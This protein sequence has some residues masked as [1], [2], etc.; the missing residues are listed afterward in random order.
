MAPRRSQRKALLCQAQV[1]LFFS[2]STGHTEDVAG[3][4]KEVASL[5]PQRLTVE[6][7]RGREGYP[8]VALSNSCLSPPPPGVPIPVA[9]SLAVE[10][11][12]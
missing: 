5:L 10:V 8:Y 1:G 4:I 2:T 12:D 7:Q 9:C 6:R 3:L 11:S